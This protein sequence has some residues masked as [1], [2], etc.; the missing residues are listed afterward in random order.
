MR[1][2]NL[3]DEQVDDLNLKLGSLTDTMIDLVKQ[4]F[5]NGDMMFVVVLS[6]QGDIDQNF[7]AGNMDTYGLAAT[8]SHALVKMVGELG[9]KLYAAE[10][11]REETEEGPADD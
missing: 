1:T 11:R 7:V 6:P 2:T 4:A 9:G 8:L 5:P 10:E 3:S